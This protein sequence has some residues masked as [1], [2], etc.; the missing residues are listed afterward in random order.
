MI[1][2]RPVKNF[3]TYNDI[4]KFVAMCK[5]Y[6]IKDV[7]LGVKQDDDNEASSGKVFYKSGIAP[8]VRGYSNFD[9]LQSMITECKK[10][11]IRVYAWIP[12]FH[13]QIAF[14]KDV[15]WEM[16]AKI[17]GEIVPY[18]GSDNLEYFVN[19]L[20]PGVQ[21]YELS[22]I[23]EIANYEGLEGIFLDWIRFDNYNMDLSDYTR[24]EYQKTHSYDPAEIDFDTSSERQNEWQDWRTTKLAEYFKKVYEAV[25]LMKPML[26]VGVFIVPPMF[27]E[28]GQDTSKFNDYVDVISP[29]A[30]FKD[31]GYSVSWVYRECI[32]QTIL[33]S[34]N[35]PII[36]CL[37]SDWS[38]RE[39]KKIYTNLPTM[40]KYAYFTYGLWTSTKLKA[41]TAV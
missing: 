34:G 30:Y 6:G 8:C 9:V 41:V 15:T 24:L 20:H 14:E 35:K 36:P 10:T 4:V 29:M 33:K 18:T 25:K 23:K 37:G 16:K 40:T 38:S 28:C 3:L 7:I 13:D 12:V 11:G 5:K 1:V 31:W 21:N 27:E 2:I 32:P 19:P 39:Y 26:Q 17:D 22:I